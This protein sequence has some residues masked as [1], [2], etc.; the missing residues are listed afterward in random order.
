MSKFSS[1]KFNKFIER[2]EL[3]KKHECLQPL[4]FGMAGR[5]LI[6][7]NERV[8]ADIAEE[9]RDIGFHDYA[10]V[11]AFIAL[12]KGIS[13]TLFKWLCLLYQGNSVPLW[14]RSWDISSDEPDL[15]GELAELFFQK[16]HGPTAELGFG[17]SWLG[18]MAI[19]VHRRKLVFRSARW[20]DQCYAAPLMRKVFGAIGYKISFVN[21]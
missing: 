17:A 8:P 11:E 19:D 10:L 13:P 3:W 12:P 2:I 7:R 15:E 9:I 4:M 20:D 1:S 18:I 6:L 16:M 21:D 5:D 14:E